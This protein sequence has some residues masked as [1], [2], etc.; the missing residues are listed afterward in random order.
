MLSEPLSALDMVKESMS[1]IPNGQIQQLRISLMNFQA[2]NPVTNRDH[3]IDEQLAVRLYRNSQST[4][5]EP[6][7]SYYD[8]LDEFYEACLLN[9]IEN[10]KV[11]FFHAR[12]MTVNECINFKKLYQFQDKSRRL[13]NSWKQYCKKLHG[14]EP[15]H[16]DQRRQQWNHQRQQHGSEEE[17]FK[18]RIKH[19]Q[20]CNVD[21]R[22]SISDIRDGRYDG[23]QLSELYDH[24]LFHGSRMTIELTCNHDISIAEKLVNLIQNDWS[25]KNLSAESLKDSRI[26]KNFL[27]NVRLGFFDREKQQYNA[28]VI[29]YG[30]CYEDKN[31]FNFENTFH[32]EKYYSFKSSS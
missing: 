13:N 24:Q 6:W 15:S 5:M 18:K 17:L 11:R 7:V 9:K 32:P 4:D 22:K 10:E 8:H 14:L 31:W 1:L 12:K 25:A 20:R 21:L 16:R 2:Y 29:F 3:H 23:A 19:Y 26:F 27:T 30:R 28:P